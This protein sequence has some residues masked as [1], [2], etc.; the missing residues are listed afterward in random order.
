[1]NEFE[2][3][4]GILMANM[5]VCHSV[6]AGIAGP[7]CRAIQT[8]AFH[9]ATKNAASKGGVFR[10]IDNQRTPDRRLYSSVAGVFVNSDADSGAIP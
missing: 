3:E 6:N 9:R 8:A 2:C 4:A 1:M 5:T 7:E 10:R